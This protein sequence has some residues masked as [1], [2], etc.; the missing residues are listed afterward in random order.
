MLLRMWGIKMSNEFQK[1]S[2]YSNRVILAQL[3]RANE[4]GEKNVRTLSL[5]STLNF[6]LKNG[7]GNIPSLTIRIFFYLAFLQ[8]TPC[9]LLSSKKT[10]SGMFIHQRQD[11]T[12]IGQQSQAKTTSFPIS[13]AVKNQSINHSNPLKK[14]HWFFSVMFFFINWFLFVWALLHSHVCIAVNFLEQKT[15]SAS[16]GFS[17]GWCISKVLRIKREVAK[18]ADKAQPNPTSCR[19]TEFSEACRRLRPAPPSRDSSFCQQGMVGFLYV[20]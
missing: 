2:S 13:W 7:S 15:P 8:N 1:D 4:N 11:S 19:K 17:S 3:Q 14:N 9:V 18:S 10:P 6:C 5:E 20:W 12:H 16:T